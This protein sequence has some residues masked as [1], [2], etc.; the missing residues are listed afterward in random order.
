M[1]HTSTVFI[2]VT[3][4]L[5]LGISCAFAAEF[6]VGSQLSLSGANA[7]GGTGMNEGIMVAA[8]V[9]NKH[10]SRH[11]VKIVTIDDESSPAKAVAA[12]EKLASQG[13]VAIAGGATSDIVG[14]A[15]ASANKLNMVYITSGGT[16]KEFVSQGYKSFFRI[17][18]TSG[19]VLAMS[20]LLTEMKIK[21]LSILYSTKK[22]TTELADGV[23]KIMTAQGVKVTLH[24]I[25][26]GT[27]D[28]KAVINKVKLRDHPDAINI[29]GY[30]NDYIGVLRAAKV[31]KPNVKAIVGAWQLATEKMARE[32]PSLLQNVYGTAMLPYP[33]AFFDKE[34]KN[35]HEAYRR[36]F[37]KEP[38][39]LGQ[40]GYVQAMVLFKAIARAIDKGT[41]KKG[42]LADELR[43]TDQE[44]VI[45]RVHFDATGDNPSFSHRMGQHQGGKIAIVW[46]PKY[47]SG[48]MNFP[49]VPW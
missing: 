31:L 11:K 9:F 42:G 32:F 14:P 7:R 23:S 3:L 38:D 5:M 20:G 29:I 6:L 17:N 21:S 35:F 41:L 2:V 4:Q 40:F 18:N 28:Y 19:Y 46:P 34:G 37:N 16:S 12:V 44:T 30:E 25:D 48:N 15:S 10:N 49:G 45:G 13:V 1:K 33:T 8:D 24:P 22:S 39:Y 36:L 47:A 43:K 27:T 26:A